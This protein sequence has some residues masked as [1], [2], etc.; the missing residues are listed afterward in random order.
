MQLYCRKGGRA[1]L[2]YDPPLQTPG[3]AGHAYPNAYFVPG[4]TQFRTAGLME[5]VRDFFFS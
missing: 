4:E 2:K 3:E 5:P 1:K